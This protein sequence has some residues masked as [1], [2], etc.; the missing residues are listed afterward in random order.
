MGIAST[1]SANATYQ[2]LCLDH[3]LGEGADGK[4]G[5]SA[6]FRSSLKSHGGSGPRHRASEVKDSPFRQDPGGRLQPNPFF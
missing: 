4:F 1:D 2:D 6:T 5:E 3:S